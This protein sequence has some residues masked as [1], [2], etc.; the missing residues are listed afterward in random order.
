MGVKTIKITCPRCGSSH[1]KKNGRT[2][3]NKQRYFC[4]ACGKQFL[5]C[6]D[7]TYH[8]C[9]PLYRKLIVPMTLNGSGIRD[10]AR[11]LGI[12]PTTVLNVLRQA[13]AE[14]PE[15]R[16]PSRIL[17]L[18]IDEQWSFVQNKGQQMWLWY[19]LNRHTGYIPAFVLGRRTDANCRKL[20][21]TLANC[22]V[23]RFYTDDWQSYTKVLPAK[24]HQVG[25]DGTQTS[26][27]KTST[28]AFIS[29]EC[30]AKPSVFP[31]LP[32]CTKMSSNST[33]ML[34]TQTR[35]TFDTRP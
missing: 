17:A 28:F 24:R 1:S 8:A 9:N 32:K 12:S 4:K 22:Q 11:V 16:V 18:E 14:V 21:Q 27:V 30:N 23:R 19:G 2:R 31:S 25:K 33:F 7:Y 29:S 15:P 13:A 5:F 26:N 6:L 35:I 34:S 3:Q 10:I 20:I